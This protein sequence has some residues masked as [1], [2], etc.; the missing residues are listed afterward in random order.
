MKNFKL[1]SKQFLSLVILGC[2]FQGSVTFATSLA[3][4][5][6]KTKTSANPVLILDTK[7]IFDEIS[8]A[9]IDGPRTG[10]GG[11]SCALA[12]TQNTT[13]LME[14][15][16][17]SMYLE[18]FP[19]FMDPEKVISTMKKTRFYIK[20]NLVK[21][22]QVKDAMNFPSQGI[23]YV[24]PKFC[25]TELIEVSGR[26]MSLLLH[27]YLGLTGIND[28][29]YEVSGKFLEVYVNG[30]SKD[31]QTK[32]WLKNEFEKDLR[33]KKSCFN[34]AIAKDIA[35]YEDDSVTMF[36]DFQYTLN[37]TPIDYD[38]YGITDGHC[39][40]L[41][42]NKHKVDYDSKDAVYSL[43]KKSKYY[44]YLATVPLLRGGRG[45]MTVYSLTYKVTRKETTTTFKHYG[46]EVAEGVIKET[47]QT[48]L[49]CSP[50]DMKWDE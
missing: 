14:L 50:H 31:A 33:G 27:E 38:G 40:P 42:K 16:S 19:G 18:I 20:E 45:L 41:D 11:N 36:K 29:N 49:E 7:T 23:I 47:F 15:L 35:E 48:T 4:D 43:C 2:A 24:S 32:V 3:A 5:S 25:A 13:T 12:I 22:G 39:E 21:D 44:T 1:N 9:P 30:K 37:I 6:A 28:R 17:Q 10:G 34:G 8:R 26:S 46:A